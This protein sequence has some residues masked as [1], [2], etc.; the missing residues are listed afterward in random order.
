MVFFGFI[1]WPA[2]TGSTLTRHHRVHH[3]KK[4][5][6]ESET[7]LLRIV[8]LLAALCVAQAFV[9]TQSRWLAATKL[10]AIKV[11]VSEEEPIENVLKRFKKT[12]NQSG[13]VTSLQ[14]FLL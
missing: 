1:I 10:S 4:R 9:A 7:M 3:S 13:T 11:S 8:A 6:S 12:V 14:F 2:H 5:R